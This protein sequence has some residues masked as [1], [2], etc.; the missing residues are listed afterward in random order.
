MAPPS[1]RRGLERVGAGLRTQLAARI[2]TAHEADQHSADFYVSPEAAWESLLD[3]Q[4]DACADRLARVA[5]LLKLDPLSVEVL[6]LC[7]APELDDRL[8]R[9]FAFMHDNASR[10]LPS[11]RLIASV[12][13]ADDGEAREV[14][15][16]LGA[17]APL[18]RYGCVE[19]IDSDVALPL[20][21]RGI[22]VAG[23][24][25]AFLL[26]GAPLTDELGGVRR[27]DAPPYPLGRT[28]TLERI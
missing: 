25:A 19:V 8:G 21:D 17:A 12:L 27:R 18:R 23:E 28:D 26:G 10:R 5:A 11:A 6:L 20:A 16:R 2:T 24:L 22:R 1:V 4:L 14:F 15:A 13:A 3:A 7:A 9:V